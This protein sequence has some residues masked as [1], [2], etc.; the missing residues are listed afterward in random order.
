MS[1]AIWTPT[2]GGELVCVRD[3]SKNGLINLRKTE[4]VSNKQPNSVYLR[5]WL[6]FKI[7]VT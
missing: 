1:V 7:R 5:E 2:S 6:N 3:I 4:A